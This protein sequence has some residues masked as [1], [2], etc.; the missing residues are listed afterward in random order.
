[1]KIKD[2]LNRTLYFSKTPSRIV[3]LVP[4]QT[5]LIVDL[6][7]R[8]YLVGLTKFCVHPKDLRKQIKVVGG[9]KEVHYD[10]I[11][12]LCPDIIICNKEENTHKMVMELEKIAPVYVSDIKTIDDSIQMVLAIGKIFSVEKKAEE[13]SKNINQELATFLEFIKDIPWKN[14]IYLIWKNPYMAVGKQTF[15][16]EMLQLNHFKNSLEKESRYPEITMKDLKKTEI[17]FLSS[18]PF[19]FKEKDVLELQKMLGLDVRIVDGE[20]FSWYGSRLQS[21]FKYFKTLH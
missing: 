15:I 6:G 4:S 17:V 12:E 9:T 20:F 18:E 2:Q 13:I 3:S 11:K 7:L 21:A 8:E 19:P 10:T 16:D 5:E 1:M 14:V